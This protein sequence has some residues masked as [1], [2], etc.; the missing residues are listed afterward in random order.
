[1]HSAHWLLEG[2]QGSEIVATKLVVVVVVVIVRVADKVKDYLLFKPVSFVR[3]LI[4]RKVG[5]RIIEGF[6]QLSSEVCC[7]CYWDLIKDA[8]LIIIARTIAAIIIVKS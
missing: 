6:H 3:C 8:K 1:M 7:C 4:G 5:V 2:L